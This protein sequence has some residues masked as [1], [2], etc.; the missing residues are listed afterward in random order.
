VIEDAKKKTFFS[1]QRGGAADPTSTFKLIDLRTMKAQAET[2]GMWWTYGAKAANTSV[3]LQRNSATGAQASVSSAHNGQLDLWEHKVFSGGT[4]AALMKT[5]AGYCFVSSP[6]PRP[7]AVSPDSVAVC[8]FGD[9]LLQDV[10][11]PTAAG[12]HCAAV[13]ADF[14]FNLDER[15]CD[16]SS[17]PSLGIAQVIRTAAIAI[18]SVEHFAS[19]CQPRLAAAL[20][21]S[22]HAGLS[23][24]PLAPVQCFRSHNTRPAATEGG[25]IVRWL[26][27]VFSRPPT[28]DANT[29]TVAMGR[30]VRACRVLLYELVRAYSLHSTASILRSAFRELGPGSPLLLASTAHTRSRQATRSVSAGSRSDFMGEALESSMWDALCTA[31]PPP[32]TR[33]SVPPVTAELGAS[34]VTQ[35]SAHSVLTMQ[36]TEPDAVEEHRESAH[37][38][39]LPWLARRESS[40]VSTSSPERPRALSLSLRSLSSIAPR[41]SICADSSMP[42]LPGEKSFSELARL[43]CWF[44]PA[45]TRQSYADGDDN[46]VGGSPTASEEFKLINC[47][48][49]DTPRYYGAAEGGPPPEAGGLELWMILA[50]RDVALPSL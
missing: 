27:S 19:I 38:W 37:K 43:R 11:L 1:S 25:G 6:S 34:L 28:M 39:C 45:T 33:P 22:E 29:Y 15:D 31:I 46:V 5:L 49:R 18:P 12:W 50:C 42:T 20:A 24:L 41:L 9:H 44:V 30:C 13:A 48:S 14:K 10:V 17:A 16:T 26:I 40:D 7:T 8:Y 35:Q 47:G 21:T 23:K 36:H 2:P 32:T 4:V 3:A